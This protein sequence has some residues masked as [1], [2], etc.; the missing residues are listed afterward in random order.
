VNVENMKITSQTKL[1]D[2]VFEL[3][4][5]GNEVVKNAVAGQFVHIKINT[6]NDPLL[7]R[8]LS[9]T[10]INNEQQELTVIY[11]VEGKGTKQLALK[12]ETEYLPVLGPLGN[13]FPIAEAK[14][15]STALLIGG[16]IG[17]PP[18]YELSLRLKE[19]DV[20]VIHVLGF[21]SKADIFYKEQFEKS[22]DTFIATIDGTYGIKGTVIDVI[23][24]QGFNFDIIYSCGPRPML[25]AIETEFPDKKGF[26]S[27][28]E[29]MGCGIG[30]CFACVCRVK[31]P[32]AKA[33]YKKICS[34]GP[35]FAIGEIEI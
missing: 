24:E 17:V 6:G 11:R 16:G 26:Q 31:D 32:L 1:T 3:V 34:D 30:A 20:N 5:Q 14:A 29:R 27:F 21:N 25:K 23:Y 35:V 10:K 4:L 19:N 9:I 7:R 15:G 13:G 8:P 12:N 28:E 18:L 22:G 2:N 33:T